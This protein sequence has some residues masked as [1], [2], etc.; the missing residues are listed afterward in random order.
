MKE[1]RV[2][3]E[4]DIEADTPLDAAKKA[5]E[6]MMQAVSPDFTANVF[7]VEDP[8]TTHKFLVDLDVQTSEEL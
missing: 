7:T 2:S 8:T 5:L 4:V 3:W 1:F 6:L